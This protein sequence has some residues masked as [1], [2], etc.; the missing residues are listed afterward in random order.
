[1]A[2]PSGPA[3]DDWPESWPQA[4]TG[5]PGRADTAPGPSGGPEAA[6][7]DRLAWERHSQAEAGDREDLWAMLCYLGVPF[8][9]F[10]APLAILL[11]RG[12]SSPFVRRHAIQALNLSITLLLYT[13]SALILGAML[14]LDTLTAALVITVP[15]LALLWLA[16]LAYLVLGAAAAGTGQP[17][18]I[19]RW[20]SATIVRDR[21]R[22]AG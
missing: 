7:P 15:A 16:T 12:R 11:T 20:I 9:S 14:A 1:M 18:E 3:A 10:A 5:W 22:P 2:H 13:L 8:L 4:G 21:P 17:Y 6:P 19:P